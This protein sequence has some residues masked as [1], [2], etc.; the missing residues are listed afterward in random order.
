MIN[1]QR[2]FSLQS[3]L[4]ESIII[5]QIFSTVGNEEIIWKVSM[6]LCTAFL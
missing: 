3:Q 5:A 2:L 4:D 6:F 1:A